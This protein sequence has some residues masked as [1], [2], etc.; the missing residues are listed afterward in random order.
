MTEQT[1]FNELNSKDVNDHVEQKNGL[2]YLAWS[3]AHE[4]LKKI[5]ANY[6]IKIHDF[7][8]PDIDRDDYFVPYLVT[9][10]GYF[11][12][13]SVTVKNQTETE[14][15]PVLDFRN[16]SLPKGKATTFDINKSQKRCFVKAAA[17]HGLGLYIYSGEE[18]PKASDNAITELEEKIKEFVDISKDNGRDATLD[19][20]MRWLG[21]QNINKLGDKD[22]AN[23]H[24][25]L[26]SALKQINKEDK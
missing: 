8:H 6:S 16:K 17:L 20:T 24:K 11:V 9:P 14:W 22:I 2:T 25:K 15:L 13:V 4:E 21:I 5:D 18:V 19:K 23:A 1:L 12:Q 7:P 10:E 3:Y 26:E